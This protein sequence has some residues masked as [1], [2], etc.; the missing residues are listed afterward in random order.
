M[1]VV[2]EW[3]RD[4][5]VPP[6]C[7]ADLLQRLGVGYETPQRNEIVGMS[8]AATSQRMRLEAASLGFPMWRNNVGA[9]LDDKGALVRFGLCNESKGENDRIKSHDYI[10]CRPVKITAAMFGQVFGLF[11]TREMK[12]EGWVYTGQGREPAQRKFQDIV[13]SLGGDAKFST[14]KGSF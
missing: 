9:L 7:V 4:W 2:H 5:R 1:S 8:E 6:A 10:G 13:L 14:G 12:E 3:A 11:T